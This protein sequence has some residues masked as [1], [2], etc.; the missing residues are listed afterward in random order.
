ME[1]SWPRQTLNQGMLSRLEMGALPL[2]QSLH[3]QPSMQ[4]QASPGDEK[5]LHL[6]LSGPHT[7]TQERKAHGRASSSGQTRRI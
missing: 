3:S 1:Q 4:H 2:V 6:R 5:A 7:S